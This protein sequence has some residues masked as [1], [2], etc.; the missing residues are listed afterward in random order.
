MSYNSNTNVYEVD[1]DFHASLSY[2]TVSDAKSQN[3]LRYYV[4]NGYRLIVDGVEYSFN[5]N[6]LKL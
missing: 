3:Q 2:E 1:D 5:I 4:G 6:P